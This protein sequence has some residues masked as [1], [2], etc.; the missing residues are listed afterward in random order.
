MTR[1]LLDLAERDIAVLADALGTDPET[2]DADLQRRPWCANDVLRHP[3]VVERVLQGTGSAALQ[4]TPLLFF[5]VMVHSAADELTDAPWVADWAGPS[6]RLPVFDVEP[7]LEFADAPGRLV[8]VA[9][10]LAD[11]AAPTPAPVPA[12]PND[13]DDLVDWLDAAEPSDRIVLLRRLGDNALFRAGVF[14]DATGSHLLSPA[15]AEHL[16][17]SV[18]MEA[19]EIAGLLDP[20]SVTPGLDALESLGSAWYRAAADASK[21]GPVV[22][23]DIAARVRPARRFLNH[24]ADRYLQQMTLDWA[25]GF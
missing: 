16:G 14:P 5:A 15:Q 13:L 1:Q 23:R 18:G 17:G 3:D 12:A 2:L 11:F 21:R 9:R 8:F 25:P 22:L 24:L 6:T 20:G 19:D 10:L 4:V 7:L